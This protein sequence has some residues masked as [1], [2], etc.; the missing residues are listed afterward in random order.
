MYGLA[1]GNALD[2]ERLYRQRSP[3]RHVPERKMLERLHRCLCETG[4]FVNG[5]HATVRGR[6]VRT[7]QVV[8]DIL[9]R[10]EDRQDISTREISRA[11]NVLHSIV[12]RVPR[13]DPTMYRDCKR[14]YLQ[15]MRH[16]S[17]SHAGFCNKSQRSLILVRM[18]YSRMK[19][20]LLVKAFL[21]R[22]TFMCGH[23]AIRTTHVLMRIRSV[24]AGIVGD[25][26]I[27]LYFLPIRLDGR[28]YIAFL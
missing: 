2:A 5:M 15:I 9:Q 4:S 22:T 11:V 8:E 3:R 13:D 24:S 6:S 10:V 16:V 17:S 25:H 1:N 21:I 14:S 7:P 23:L 20:P 27:G 26:L 18:C 28:T 12:W 19:A